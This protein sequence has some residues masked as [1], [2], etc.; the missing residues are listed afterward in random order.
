MPSTS[1]DRLGRVVTEMDS[2]RSRLRSC[3]SMRVSVVFPAP[4]AGKDQ[5]YAAMVGLGEDMERF[6][7]IKDS[8][9]RQGRGKSL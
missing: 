1:L 7:W 9:S 2:E 4:R 5:H 8:K 3:S 6:G